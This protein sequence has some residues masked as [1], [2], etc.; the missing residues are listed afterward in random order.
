MLSLICLP[1][2]EIFLLFNGVFENSALTKESQDSSKK[3]NKGDRKRKRR[4]KV[5][6]E[7]IRDYKPSVAGL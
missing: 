1:G 3:K 6:K 5:K 2:K 7:D 4:Q